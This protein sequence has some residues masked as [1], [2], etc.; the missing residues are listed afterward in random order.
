MVDNRKA[1][2]DWMSIAT[3]LKTISQAG[4]TF[5]QNDYELQRH[6]DI[7]NITAEILAAYT[8]LEEK[9][10][11]AMLQKDCGYPTPKVDS[12]GVIF[13]D[14]KILLVKEI[15][16]GGWTLPG[17]WCDIGMTPAEN[18]VREVFEESGYQTRAVK[19]L[20]VYDRKSQGHTPHYPFDIY[21]MFFMCEI[22][23]GEPRTS[24]ETSAVDFF[25]EDEIPP[26]SIPRTLPHQIKLFFEYYRN[27]DLPTDFDYPSG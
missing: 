2:L 25:A 16:D 20:A 11:A 14:D 5:A 13:K 8:N 23:S 19:L 1:K 15:A 27:P 9:E 4:K 21:K 12:R 7:E 24:N 26:L 18:V 10:I 17:G 22:I 6:L 3:R